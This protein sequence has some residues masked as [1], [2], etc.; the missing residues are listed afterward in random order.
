MSGVRFPF[1]VKTF[2][3]DSTRDA[4][5]KWALEVNNGFSKHDFERPAPR[6]RPAQFPDGKDSTDWIEIDLAENRYVYV[7]GKVRGYNTPIMLDSG[8]GITLLPR[9][10]GSVVRPVHCS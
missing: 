9:L 2:H 6:S 5:F 8:G 1:A 10:L 4:T 3:D 7:Q